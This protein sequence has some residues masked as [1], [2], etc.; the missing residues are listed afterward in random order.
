[1]RSTNGERCAQTG[2]ELHVHSLVRPLCSSERSRWPNSAGGRASRWRRAATVEAC[3]VWSGD[4]AGR[5]ERAAPPSS[6]ALPTCSSSG[7]R[8]RRLSLHLQVKPF[9]FGKPETWGQRSGSQNNAAAPWFNQHWL[10]SNELT[11]SLHI[12]DKSHKGC[13]TMT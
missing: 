11:S 4:S 8:R 13:L 9:A 12:N 5:S 6:V 7:A 10:E 1:M 2:G 3:S